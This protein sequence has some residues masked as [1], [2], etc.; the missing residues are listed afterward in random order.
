MMAGYLRP[1]LSLR[2]VKTPKNMY[3]LQQFIYG[4]EWV[5]LKCY[6]TEREARGAM[7]FILD[8]EIIAESWVK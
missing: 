2:I 3:A 4:D 6:K 5:I 7:K 1:K 8:P